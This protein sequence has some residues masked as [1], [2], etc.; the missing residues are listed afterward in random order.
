MPRPLFTDLPALM[1]NLPLAKHAGIGEGAAQ[2][3]LFGKFSGLLMYTSFGRFFAVA[4]PVRVHLYVAAIVS[5]RPLR[6][7]G[8]PGRCV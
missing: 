7:A 2:S 3:Q 4:R 5:A 8:A 6:D 1:Q